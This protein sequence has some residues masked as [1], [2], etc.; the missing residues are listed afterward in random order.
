MATNGLSLRG[1]V[2]LVTAG[3]LAGHAATVAKAQVDLGRGTTRQMETDLRETWGLSNEMALRRATRL[4]GEPLKNTQG[5]TLGTIHDLVLTPDLDA[6][7]YAV[8]SRGGLFGLGKR[9][10]AIPWSAM[11]AGVGD[12]IVAPIDDRELDQDRGFRATQWPSEGD[13][14]WLSR[15]GQRT[16]QVTFDVQPVTEQNELRRRRVSRILGMNARGPDNSHVGVLK[17]MLIAMNTGDIPFKIVSYGGLL[18]IGNKYTAVPAGAIDLRPAEYVARVQVSEQILQAN[19]FNPANFPDL[20]DPTYAQRIY[21]AYRVPPEDPDWVVLG[22]VPPEDP[23]RTRTTTPARPQTTFPTQRQPMQQPQPQFF[24]DQ[25]ATQF[26]GRQTQQF[27]GRQVPQFNGNGRTRNEYLAIFTPDNLRTID[28]VVTGVSTFQQV[29]TN[30]EWVQLQVRSDDGGLVTVHLGP[31]DYISRQDF[32]VA[33][34]DRIE[35]TGAQATAWRQPIILPIT[36]SVGTQTIT[37]RDQNGHPLW[38]QM[39]APQWDLSQPTR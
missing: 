18:G 21:A 25:Q 14:R 28:G 6:V 1:L 38:D 15:A 36:A 39:L 4:L 33:S 30:A 31:R 35:L 12:T 22:Y 9:L 16:E 24:N 11:R 29:G 26:N 3:L 19:A 13:P 34:N 23:V 20:A 5:A 32:Y 7:S 17:D 2:I 8:I 37:L 10:Y 27:N